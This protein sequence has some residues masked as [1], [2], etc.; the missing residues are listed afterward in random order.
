MNTRIKQKACP[1]G[2][3]TVT[4]V[5]QSCPHCLGIGKEPTYY[6]GAPFSIHDCSVCKGKKIISAVTGLPPQ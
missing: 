3:F 1:N 2:K 6:P 4:G 5:W